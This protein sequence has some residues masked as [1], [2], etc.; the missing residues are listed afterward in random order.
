M[1]ES[2]NAPCYGEVTPQL[3]GV[4][5]DVRGEP[6]V[7]TGEIATALG[8]SERVARAQLEPRRQSG[9]IC[10]KV[11]PDGQCWWFIPDN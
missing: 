5:L 1:V 8:L 11:H 10:C 3:V 4:L 6:T 9:E 7:T 2:D